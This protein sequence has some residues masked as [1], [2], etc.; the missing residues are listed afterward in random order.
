MKRMLAMF[1]LALAAVLAHPPAARAQCNEACVFFYTP[2]GAPGHGC[3]VDNDSG[4]ACYARSTRCYVKQCSNALVTDPSGHILAVADICKDEVTV[5]PV[6]R[7]PA[8]RSAARPRAPM[9][10]TTVAS[11]SVGAAV[12]VG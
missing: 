10:S 6:R 1:A 5:R 7:G 8:S 12:R 11:A 2:G 3:V 9:R 4:A